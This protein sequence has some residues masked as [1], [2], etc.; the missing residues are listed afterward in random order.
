MGRYKELYRIERKAKDSGLSPD[1]RY[2]LR[3]K[4]SKPLMESFQKWLDGIQSTVLPQSPL[5]K[6]IQ[7]CQNRWS[8]LMR[9]L[10]DG[11]LEIDNNLTEQK[12]KPIVMARKNFLFAASVAGAKALCMHFSFIQTAKLH[13]HD[14][15]HYYV[16]VLKRLPHCKT[17]EDYEKLL[18]W[19]MNPDGSYKNNTC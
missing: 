17:L 18:P 13:G 8:G 9:F 15:Y 6:A 5:G 16:I 1:Y 7:Y 10:D 14:P 3:Q 11:R 12:I 19:N 2:E 4:E